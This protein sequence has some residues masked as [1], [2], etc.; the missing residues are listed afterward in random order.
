M[1][2][3]TYYPD[4][5]ASGNINLAPQGSVAPPNGMRRFDVM[6]PYG[7]RTTYIPMNMSPD[8]AIAA[9]H[10]QLMP[11]LREQ[12]QAV[13][14]ASMKENV[15]KADIPVD[16][17]FG[18]FTIPGQYPIAYGEGTDKLVQA[19]KQIFGGGGPAQD[20]AVAQNRQQM[21]N[22]YNQYPESKAL[23]IAGQT[24]PLAA[25]SAIATPAAATATPTA[26]FLNAIGQGGAMGAAQYVAPGES[27]LQNAIQ[28][29][30][31][32][33]ILQ[34]PFSLTQKLAAGPAKNL[35]PT[36]QDA[37][38]DMQAIPGVR[39]LPSQLT[40]SP[41][42]QGGE[43]VAGYFPFSAGQFAARIAGNRAGISQQAL[44]ILGIDADAGTPDVLG[45][46]EK[47]ATGTLDTIANSGATVQLSPQHIEALD[48]IRT[49]SLG[50]NSPNPK[51]TGTINKLIGDGS[52]ELNPT[53]AS[54]S[55]DMQSQ[56]I[57]VLG[58]S[59][60]GPPTA[61][62][63][64]P[65]GLPMPFFQSVQSDMSALSGKGEYLAGQ[66]NGVLDN[67]A[68]T[69]LPGDWGTQWKNARQ[70]YG[71][72][73][74]AAPAFNPA[75]GVLDPRAL[76]TSLSSSGST[77][78]ARFL[79]SSNPRLNALGELA[80]DARGMPPVPE[81]GSDTAAKLN[82][83]H[84][85]GAI[86]EGLL[87]LGAAV[88]GHAVSGGDV[89]ATGAAATLPFLAANYLTK[90]YLS[91][92]FAQYAQQGIPTLGEMARSIAPVYGAVAPAV[93]ASESSQ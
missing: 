87:G 62:P 56:A 72:L 8:E 41:W 27:R 90:G 58:K 84:V 65:N 78:V 36:Q 71:A 30:K 52:A 63:K 51:L 15:S 11:K 37:V 24:I 47:Q 73:Q 13:L 67:A 31:T 54:M 23:S 85:I 45:A 49:K 2:D 39:P 34:A 18:H 16:T 22:F 74:V 66:T 68:E 3:P 88:G 80:N 81:G 42:L 77:D 19:G 48:A 93:A 9:V 12:N 21:Q 29:A 10:Q 35:T 59:A 50:T 82:T 89:L 76:T 28:G 25:V 32:A 40:G 69:S 17:P 70:Q 14:D 44:R 86:G 92:A 6:T 43:K 61:Q 4:V 75:T 79:D 83:Q 91:P 46:I 33:A 64:F 26:S 20:I 7:R 53:I 5:P 38:N 1:A 57:A 60:F 55:P